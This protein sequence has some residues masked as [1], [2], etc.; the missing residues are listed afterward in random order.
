[1]SWLLRAREFADADRTLVHLSKVGHR[2]VRPGLLRLHA[3]VFQ[4]GEQG[5]GRYCQSMGRDADRRLG[6]RTS[7]QD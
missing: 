7:Q 4:I 1:M 6:R 5:F 3:G 2:G